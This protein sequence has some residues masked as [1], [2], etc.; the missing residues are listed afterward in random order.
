M[1]QFGLYNT[2]THGNVTRKHLIAF[3]CLFSSSKNGKQEGK[4]GAVWGVGT[5]GRG[6]T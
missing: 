6:R 2:Y 1:N 4:T 5:S 3:F